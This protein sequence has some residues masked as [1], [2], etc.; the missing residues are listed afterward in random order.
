[1]TR[2]TPR[3]TIGGA[4]ATFATI[5]SF[6]LSTV[7]AAAQEDRCNRVDDDGDGK[8]DFADEDCATHP[9]CA[10]DFQRGD[11]DLDARIN[12]TDAIILLRLAFGGLPDRYFCDD[13]KDVNDDGSLDVTDAIVLIE[14]LFRSGPAPPEPFFTC[15][16]D[17]TPDGLFCF[18]VSER[19]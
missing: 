4:A 9:E 19:C 7:T 8:V 12:V 2:F 13:A 11:V 6:L 3:R 15:G 18:T 1:M 10:T 14:W 5:A 16:L 17:Q